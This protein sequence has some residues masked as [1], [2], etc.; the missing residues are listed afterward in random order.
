MSIFSNAEREWWD[1]VGVL[2]KAEG[3]HREAVSL[4][5][6]IDRLLA[7]ELNAIQ[8][9]TSAEQEKKY[10]EFYRDFIAW[11][12]SEH[13]PSTLPVS[14]SVA[15]AWAFSRFFAERDPAKVEQRL[16]AIRH[17]NDFDAYDEAVLT[18]CRT[19]G[20]G[21]GGHP[22]EAPKSPNDNV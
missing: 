3:E 18:W 7:Q 8:D 14:G 17:L 4:A 20:D 11:A 10:V 15:A 12:R 22:I 5:P 9:R 21:G 1:L 13:L 19:F 16:A 2:C 6:H